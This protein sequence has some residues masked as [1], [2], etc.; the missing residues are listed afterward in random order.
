[1]TRIGIFGAGA[2]GCYV[3]G[4]LALAGADVVFVGRE[5][6]KTRL[7]QTGLTVSDLTG[8][9]GHVE[10]D[11]L[12]FETCEQALAAADTILV[13]VKSMDTEQVGQTLAI[14][15]RPDAII[16]SLQNG[17]SNA[18]MLRAHLPG[19]TVLAG[20]IPFNV[21]EL[22]TGEF[23]QS[24]DGEIQ[25]EAHSGM[26]AMLSG[27]LDKAVLRTAFTEDM[28]A[29]LWS[30]LLMNLNN[31]IN[32]LSGLPLK[33]QLEDRAFRLC[34]ALC[35]REALAVLKIEGA[36]KPI[37]LTR[38][39]PE[40]LPRLMSLPNFIYHPLMRRM[41]AI[42]PLARSSMADDLATGRT[43]EVDWI[44]GEVVRLAQNLGRNAPVNKRV[45]ELVKAAFSDKDFKSWSGPALI[46]DLR[47]AQTQ[48]S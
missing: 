26:Q 30:K 45:V 23:F 20:M 18:D 24:V 37:K 14:V 10:P 27:L 22:E 36:V 3:G 34:T 25:I 31:G 29:V 7:S 4:R 2:I 33:A 47:N 6:L 9:K 48:V 11:V 17:V 21:A 35:I 44:N 1:M 16:I 5:R 8:W 41:L 42:D 46:S 43:P 28:R 38:V 15:A 39:R 32:A 19:H 13:C 40:L 12:R